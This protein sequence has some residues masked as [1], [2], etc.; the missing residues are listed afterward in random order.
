MDKIYDSHL[1]QQKRP[2]DDINLAAA[3]NLSKKKKNIAPLN[4]FINFFAFKLEE[5]KMQN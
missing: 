3:L 2:K 4:G 1:T 5:A